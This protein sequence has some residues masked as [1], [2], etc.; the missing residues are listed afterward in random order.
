MVHLRG[1]NQSC[2]YLVLLGG[3]DFMNPF[4]S[5]QLTRQMAVDVNLKLHKESQRAR[6]FYKMAE[7]SQEILLPHN[8]TPHSGRSF[9]PNIGHCNQSNQT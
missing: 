7:K 6:A 1:P 5:E 9:S 2:N 3:W 8:S 4:R